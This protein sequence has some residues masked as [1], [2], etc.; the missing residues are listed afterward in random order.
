MNQILPHN[1]RVERSPSDS[2]AARAPGSNA[3]GRS[4]RMREYVAKPMKGTA[5]S[6]AQEVDR[7]IE[8]LSLADYHLRSGRSKRLRE[9][10]YPI[11]RLALH[12]KQPGLEVEV[13]AFE[14][15][16]TADGRI[17][18]SGFW[19][20][21]FEVQVICDHS[22]EESLRS[23]MLASEGYTPGA[24]EIA[25]DKKTKRLVAISAAVDHDEHF[26]RIAKAVLALFQ[27]KASLAYGSSTFL[28]IAFDEVKLRGLA[29]W[30]RLFR[31]LEAKGGLANSNFVAVYLF[32]C[33]TN[34]MQKAA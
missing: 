9:E 30:T 26:D 33:A 21:D 2:K 3:D 32:N 25:R 7:Q 31:T 6:F 10:L 12:I 16:G 8:V 4:A 11:S 20:D 13:E 19:E 22:Y 27:K 23:E 29:S 28:I 5:Y 17:R 14:N 15:S 18:V 1:D 34:E 24:G